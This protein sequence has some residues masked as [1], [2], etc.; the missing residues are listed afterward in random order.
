MKGF[1]CGPFQF[2]TSQYICACMNQF[3]T[4]FNSED[5]RMIKS[6]KFFP[7]LEGFQENIQGIFKHL[8]KEKEFCDVTLVCEDNQQFE[9]HKVILSASSSL[10]RDLLKSTKHSHPLLYMWGVKTRDLANVIDFIYNGQ[11][12]IYQSDLNEF[13]LVARQFQLIGINELDHSEELNETK[14]SNAVLEDVT[15]TSHGL[16]Q[17]EI[18][19]KDKE[20]ENIEHEK[21]KLGKRRTS[22]IW[23]YFSQNRNDEIFVHCNIENC[24]K[25]LNRGK[26]RTAGNGSMINHIESFHQTE[27]EE[28]VV[29]KEEFNK[30]INELN[31][32]DEL[33]ETEPSNAELVADTDILNKLNQ[34]DIEDKVQENI[35]DEKPKIEKRKTS[36]IWQYFSHN[37]NDKTSAHCNIG[38]CG[39]NIS[40]GK[41]RKSAGNGGMINHLKSIHQTEF[42]EYEANKVE[43][44]KVNNKSDSTFVH[45]N[46]DP[47]L[48][49]DVGIMQS[50]EL[51]QTNKKS[52][53][54]W[55]YFD[56]D[57]DDIDQSI[58]VCQ[59]RSTIQEMITHGNS[60]FYG[61]KQFAGRRLHHQGVSREAWTE[62]ILVHSSSAET[63][64]LSWLPDREDRRD[65]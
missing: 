20:Q 56:N 53:I 52:S 14:P 5:G 1:K 48:K 60:N 16:N 29:N 3:S 43:F 15:D 22:T 35:K 30:S 23:N 12:E 28:Y 18:E 46:L 32:S 8:Q 21:T 13:L 33:N 27:F 64:V 25:K 39:K 65:N 44:R 10:L 26:G 51:E 59:V 57:K 37:K 34:Q 4:V 61:Q 58:A 17:Q 45:T 9:A 49:V 36:T 41:S 2:S 42:E 55:N 50:L 47:D 6:D 19:D 24:G 31:H 62:R 63:L 40:R 54:I 7:R 38:N 11:V